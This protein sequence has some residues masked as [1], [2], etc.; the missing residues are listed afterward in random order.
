[1]QQQ[2]HQAHKQN[3]RH[4]PV[5]KDHVEELEQFQQTFRKPLKCAE[6]TRATKVETDGQ[7][8]A[9]FRIGR[10]VQQF[11]TARAGE[12]G[13]VQVFRRTRREVEFVRRQFNEQSAF[14]GFTSN[15]APESRF[16]RGKQ[17]GERRCRIF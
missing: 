1:M 4:A 16:D 17:R 12:D 9:E 14:V 13:D 5:T 2:S 3:D 6:G 7:G 8:Q 11:E 10:L 15:A